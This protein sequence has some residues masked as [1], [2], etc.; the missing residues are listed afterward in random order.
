MG[1][2]FDTLFVQGNLTLQDSELVAGPRANVPTNPVRNLTGASEYVANFMIGYDS[3]NSKHT[4]YLIYNVFGERLYVAGRNGAPDGFERP[5]Q[6]LDFTY[7]WYPTERV[8]IK[9]KAQNLLG[10]VITIE[11]EGVATFEEDPGSTFGLSFSWS[12]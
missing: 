11:R 7:F 9:F 12:M 10:E 2:A 4:A 3:S 6:S 8:A 5:F 1:G